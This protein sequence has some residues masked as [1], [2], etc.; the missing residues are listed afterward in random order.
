[1][2]K[3]LSLILGFVLVQFS[4]VI[5]AD[6]CPDTKSPPLSWGGLPDSWVFYDGVAIQGED[7]MS[8]VQ[9]QIQN[10]A[11]SPSNRGV[12]CTYHISTG[13]FLI[14]K[15]GLASPANTEWGKSGSDFLC[16]IGLISLCEF[17]IV[18]LE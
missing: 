8:F 5:Y 13:H 15:F 2:N 1:M 9:A 16:K 17:N 14:K 11:I 18:P 6:S 10:I 12:I 3:Y 4:L 7:G